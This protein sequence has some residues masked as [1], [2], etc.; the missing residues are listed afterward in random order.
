MGGPSSIRAD[1]GLR[2]GTV[3]VQDLSVPLVPQI[4]RN[5]FLWFREEI[6]LLGA[7]LGLSL[8]LSLGFV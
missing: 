4:P 5:R 8:E 2:P 7:L 3:D 1:T 6:Q